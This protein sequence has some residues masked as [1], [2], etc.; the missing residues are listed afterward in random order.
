MFIEA[1]PFELH[2]GLN[3]VRAERRIIEQKDPSLSSKRIFCVAHL[4]PTPR[5]PAGL[6][7]TMN[8]VVPETEKEK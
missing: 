1:G 3:W 7:T 4:C 5:L 2:L 8:G 6:S